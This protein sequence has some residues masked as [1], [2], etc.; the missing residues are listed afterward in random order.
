MQKRIILSLLVVGL[1]IVIASVFF[2][3]PRE[4]HVIRVVS[5]PSIIASLPHWVAEERGLYKA[6]DLEI[7]TISFNSSDLMIRA[8]YG[9]DADFLPAV[10]LL[11]VAQAAINRGSDEVR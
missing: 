8:L 3:R 7:Q 10:S 5:P 9:G 4:M 2:I 1:A 6:H 11:D